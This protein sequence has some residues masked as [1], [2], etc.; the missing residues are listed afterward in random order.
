MKCF[1]SINLVFD[2]L[3][4]IKKISKTFKETYD[5][6]QKCMFELLKVWSKLFLEKRRRKLLR[7]YEIC[8]SQQLYICKSLHK[9][10]FDTCK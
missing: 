8:A 6:L 3:K 2:I 1:N 4:K 5:N 9:F 7:K 10:K